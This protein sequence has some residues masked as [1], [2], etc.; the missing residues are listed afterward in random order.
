[1]KIY[2]NFLG[3]FILL[4]NHLDNINGDVPEHFVEFIDKFDTSLNNGFIKIRHNEND[5]FVHLSYLQWIN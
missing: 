5:Y 3:N 1:M 2:F 4:D